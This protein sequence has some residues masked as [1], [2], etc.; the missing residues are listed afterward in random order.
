MKTT[1]Y[2][3]GAGNSEGVRLALRINEVQT[4]WKK[5]VIL[6]DDTTKHGKSILGVEIIGPFAMLEDAD[7]ESSEITN[8]VA[9]SAAKR[10]LA[11]GKIEQYGVPFATLIHPNVDIH[12]AEI[13]PG[14]IAYQNS[15]IGPEAYI[16]EGSVIFMGAAAGHESRIGCC[17]ILAPNA[18]VNARVKLGDGVYVGTNS[19]IMP[20]VNVGAWVTIGAGSSVIRDVPLG[21]TVMGVPSK[22]VVTLKQKLNSD[23]DETLPPDI[24][25]ELSSHFDI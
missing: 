19:S 16:A 17:C 23:E 18:V 22:T 11:R 9:R 10:W 7:T 20:E 25:E 13:S 24:R 6:D 21:V 3:C 5:I 2:L 8:L 15:I 4:R 14:V 1:L 12:G